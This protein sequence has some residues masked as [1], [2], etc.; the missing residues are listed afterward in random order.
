MRAWRLRE[1]VAALIAG[2][3]VAL[4]A[5]ATGR[6]SDGRQNVEARMN[7]YQRLQ[8]VGVALR[9]E[10]DS[11]FEVARSVDAS[12]RAPARDETVP[13]TWWFDG[14]SLK[15]AARSQAVYEPVTQYLAHTPAPDREREVL[16]PFPAADGTDIVVVRNRIGSAA[17]A[18]WSAAALP[19]DV[20]FE[21]CGLH[22]LLRS[23]L[24][25][26][27]TEE[28]A[29]R[30]QLL[31][32]S[33]PEGLDDP[34]TL[35]VD[36]P[37]ARWGLRAQP[38]AG[39]RESSA[40]ARW[41][42]IATLGSCFTAAVMVL[43]HRR[44][45]LKEELDS[46]SRRFKA[47]NEQLAEALVHR[48]QAQA[49]RLAVTQL[50]SATGLMNRAAFRDV[51]E[52]ELKAIRG[53]SAS[54]LSVLVVRF[55][56]LPEVTT[57]Y[58]RDA[59]DCTLREAA[60]RFEAALG[61]GTTVA[62]IGDL[63]LA[64][65]I[66]GLEEREAGERLM[67]QLEEQLSGPFRLAKQEIYLSKAL[68]LR[69][70]PDG[71]GYADEV[72]DQASLAAQEATQK[73]QARYAVFERQSRDRRASR[74]QLEADFRRS[75]V[76]G[77]LHL[78]Y[79]P[80]VATENGRLAGFEALLRWQHPLEGVLAP[81]RFLPVVESMG[82]ALELDRWVLRQAM[83]QARQWGLELERDFFISVNASAQHFAR[84][85]LAREVED[86]LAECGVPTERLR[87]E[88]TENA[89]LGDMK[90]ASRVA[91][92]LRELGVQ[93]YLDDF[94][95]GYS[96]LSYLRLLALDYVKIDRSFIT[97]MVSESK[98]FGMVKAI[99]DLV[100]YL[101][102]QCVAEGVETREQHE[103]LQVIGAD[104]CQGYLFSKPVASDR[105][106][107]MLREPELQRRTA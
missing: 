15:T 70:Q 51:I 81:D 45:E 7:V 29:Q 5:W 41:V 79:Q 98:D 80:V 60:A 31:F 37:G 10:L 33:R 25:L 100:H 36:L 50:D 26:E 72:I 68:G 67:Q 93:L 104:W 46:L 99:V 4:L 57:T 14:V 94:G 83:L 6:S 77:G 91:A 85:T 9:S 32:R 106:E 59:A 43:L 66:I 40:L 52:R 86:I 39:W 95:T 13:A 16:G 21:S 73:K 102:M 28:S 75:L 96:S 101:E 11:L 23:G 97:R 69:F 55:D 78:N 92:E 35:A 64:G 87:L 38:R 53:G 12:A 82:L 22:D 48:E 88:I 65:C 42:L 61:A 107:Q 8:V 2:G 27:L 47:A 56:S 19:L 34:V 3:L 17:D 90:S 30:Q 74:L 58:G 20:L 76:S 62:R 63:E 44:H 24:D 18:S 105:A 1:I 49:D 71:F 54:R 84:T 89:L 103:L